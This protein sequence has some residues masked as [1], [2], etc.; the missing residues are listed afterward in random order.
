M[1]QIVKKHHVKLN[2][3]NRV[4]N[5]KT[6]ILHLH[7]L[8]TFFI[9]FICTLLFLNF[10]FQFSLCCVINNPLWILF[11]INY[12]KVLHSSQAL[13]SQIIAISVVMRYL[14]QSSINFHN[15]NSIYRSHILK[16]RLHFNRT[17]SKIEFSIGQQQQKDPF[18]P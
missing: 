12:G 8:N 16:S 11:F 6:E 14:K 7:I 9:Q 15:W 4:Q 18:C 3:F 13:Y 17:H 5:Q 1:T 2:L 10:I